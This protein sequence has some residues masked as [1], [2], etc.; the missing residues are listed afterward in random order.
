MQL[1]MLKGEK[2]SMFLD[3]IVFFDRLS[4]TTERRGVGRLLG[5]STNRLVYFYC[6][7]QSNAASDIFLGPF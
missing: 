5:L 4:S 7:R 6:L 2:R 1:L 3:S